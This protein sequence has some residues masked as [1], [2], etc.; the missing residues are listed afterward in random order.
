MTAQ[1]TNTPADDAPYWDAALETQTRAD[2]DA[3]KLEL[4]KAH[5]QRAYNGSPYYR[6]SFDT[7]GVH[8]GQVSSLDDL[9][10]FPFIDKQA[11]RDR[12]LAVPPLGDLVAVPERDVVLSLGIERIDR[13]ADGL[14]FHGRR[15]R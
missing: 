1:P 4:L 13:G 2:W 10:R 6:A 3:M 7:A 5:L 12:Q 9:R 8:P 14:P 15:F 11:L